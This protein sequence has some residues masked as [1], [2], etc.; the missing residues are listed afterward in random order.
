MTS[1]ADFKVLGLPKDA[2]WDDVKKSFRRLARIYHPDVAGPEGARKFVEIT[3]AYM[4]LKESISPEAIPH[5]KRNIRENVRSAQKTEVHEE[6]TSIF[7]VF[8][9]K[10]FSRRSDEKIKGCGDEI[11]PARLRFI[12]SVISRAESQICDILSRRG[13]F[14]AQSRTEAIVRRLKSR[15]PEVVVL[16]LKRISRRNQND[17]II[18]AMID[19]FKSRAPTTEILGMVLEI[20]AGVTDSSL[21]TRLARA[22]ML[23]STKFSARDAIMILKCFKRWKLNAEY[24]S[25]FLSHDS[26]DVVAAALNSWP[27]GHDADDVT[28]LLNLLKRDEEVILIPLLRLLRH[29][30]IPLW[31]MQRL[32]KI[33]RDHTSPA[34]RVWASA[35]VRDQNVS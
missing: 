7:R 1:G 35:I 16:A 13:E 27:A 25:A 15:H 32:T 21:R 26:N 4:T 6:H 8:W 9:R 3:E 2:S 12:G 33:M 23:S 24:S 29:K 31:T 19:C 20:F 11:S 34:V 30:K 5:V 18:Q 22:L 10:L 28:E 14:D 17:E